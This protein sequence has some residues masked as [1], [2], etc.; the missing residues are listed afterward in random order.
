M[1]GGA[2][3]SLFLSDILRRNQIDAQDVKLI[4]HA[5]SH[6]GFKECYN[7]AMIKEYTQ[8]QDQGFSD[9]FKYWIVFIS[10]KGTHCKFYN[11]Y[12]V[13]GSKPDTINNMPENFPHPEWFKGER[14]F[15]DLE[16]VEILSD[17]K[18]RL[19][20][21]WGKGTRKW[22]QK[23][24][25]DKAIIAIQANPKMVFNG[26]EKLVLT[27][28]ELKEIL[29]DTITY[30]EWHTALSSI[31]AIYL[32]VDR[33]NG[34]Q[35]VGSAYGKDGLLGRWSIYAATGHGNN[36][37]MKEA[38]CTYPDR[39]TEF[40]FSILQI[41]PKNLTDDE[42]INIESLYKKKLLTKEFGMND[43]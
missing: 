24:T 3:A 22:A 25:N 18:D 21:D 10:D 26:F 13:I 11:C 12:K 28:D 19:I 39:Y 43:N 9:G 34:K 6:D 1:D 38:V 42:I 14:E 7:K 5:L 23:G 35:Y 16:E 30:S 33:K 20:I 31:Y 29:N 32:I 17:L 8:Q 15:Y 41:L 36:K 37:L 27:H 40:Q 4:R 2:M